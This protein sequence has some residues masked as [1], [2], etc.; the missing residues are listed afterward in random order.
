M[1]QSAIRMHRKEQEAKKQATQ[2]AMPNLLPWQQ[3][4]A[5]ESFQH[6]GYVCFVSDEVQ[7]NHPAQLETFWQ[8]FE[9]VIWHSFRGSEVRDVLGS[10]WHLQKPHSSLPPLPPP[11]S[12]S[13]TSSSFSPYSPLEVRAEDSQS[14]LSSHTSFRRTSQSLRSQ[15][16]ALKPG[17]LTNTFLLVDSTCMDSVLDPSGWLDNMRVLALEA[18][19]PKPGKMYKDGYEGYTWVRL[20]HISFNLLRSQWSR[21]RAFVSCDEVNAGKW[22]A[23]TAYTGPL[24][25]NFFREHKQTRRERLCKQKNQQQETASFFLLQLYTSER[26]QA[27]EATNTGVPPPFFTHS[28][29]KFHTTTT[30]KAIVHASTSNGAYYNSASQVSPDSTETSPYTSSS[31]NSIT[32]KTID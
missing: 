24:E 7:R 1:K 6:W 30:L 9:G 32:L 14:I 26:P 25:W 11:R 21:N 13:S 12:H 27:Y 31:M 23:S 15:A 22:A 10:R 20:E 8:H 4:L 19:Y 16:N 18:D 17:L 28:P 3:R 29:P 5:Q 2:R